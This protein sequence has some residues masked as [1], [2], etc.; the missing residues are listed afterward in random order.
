MVTVVGG[1]IRF[2]IG[3]E[4]AVADRLGALD[5]VS[6]FSLQETGRMGVLVEATDIDEAHRVLTQD[7]N[8]VDDVLGVWPIYVH[9]EPEDVDEPS[10]PAAAVVS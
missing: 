3:E 8:G 10:E 9:S 4:G 1:L 7:V 5:G 2:T 6:T